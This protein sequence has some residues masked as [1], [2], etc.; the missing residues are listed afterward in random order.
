MVIEQHVSHA[1]EL[2]D[3]V[4]V[5]EHGNMSWT[6]PSSEATE[7]VQAFLEVGTSGED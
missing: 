3:Q 5:L 1:L 6:G 2:C 7:R 4:A